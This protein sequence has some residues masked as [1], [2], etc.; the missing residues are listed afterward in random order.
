MSLFILLAAC[1]Q[2]QSEPSSYRGKLKKQYPSGTQVTVETKT[3]FNSSEDTP[4]PTSDSAKDC[5]VEQKIGTV[6]WESST[7]S[8]CSKTLPVYFNGGSTL[9]CHNPLPIQKN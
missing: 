3:C 7:S 5:Y 6:I 4:D 8:Q 1:T 2:Q 9:Q